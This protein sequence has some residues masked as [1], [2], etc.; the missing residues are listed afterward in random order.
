MEI[1]INEDWLCITIGMDQPG[2]GS[3]DLQAISIRIMGIWKIK[4]LERV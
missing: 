1:F 4:L 2:D 3:I